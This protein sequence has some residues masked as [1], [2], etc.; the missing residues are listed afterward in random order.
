MLKYVD[1]LSGTEIPGLNIP[2]GVPL[3][4]ELDGDLEPSTSY[5]LG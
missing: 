4:C 3:A 5:Y 2:T 1:A